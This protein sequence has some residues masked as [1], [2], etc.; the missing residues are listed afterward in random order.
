MFNYNGNVDTKAQLNLKTCRRHTACSFSGESIIWRFIATQT[1]RTSAMTVIF[2]IGTTTTTKNEKKKTFHLGKH[3]C[4]GDIFYANYVIERTHDFWLSTYKPIC[5]CTL[6]LSHHSL[7]HLL[8]SQSFHE[9]F[10]CKFLI[11]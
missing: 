7:L 11:S 10:F 2:K 1:T 5:V 8:Y 3:M 9:I 4:G 6:V